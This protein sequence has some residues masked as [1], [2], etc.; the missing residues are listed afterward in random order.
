MRATEIIRGVLDI[1]DRAE[2]GEVQT[3]QPIPAQVTMTP[4]LPGFAEIF[5]QMASQIAKEPES[6]PAMYDNSPDPLIKDIH[7][8]TTAAGLSD[9]KHPHDLRGKDQPLFP[10]VK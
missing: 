1:I 3:A 8:V 9:V 2:C 5:A 6:T 4:P 7:S 10:A